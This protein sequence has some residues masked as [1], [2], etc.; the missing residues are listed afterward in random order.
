MLDNVEATTFVRAM[1]NG[2]TKPAL[3]FAE[4]LDGSEIEVVAKFSAGCGVGGL[5]REAISSC[6]ATDLGLPM[7][8]A[9]LIDLTPSFIASVPD[10]PMQQHMAAGDFMA[11]ATVKLPNG[12]ASWIDTGADLAPAL[13]RQAQEILCF[14]C[15]VTNA[16]RMHKN[17]NLLTDGTSFAIFDHELALAHTMN[18]F[19][20][21]PWI[22]K[23]LDQARPPVEHV[24][25]QLLRGRASYAL[26]SLMTRLAALTDGRIDSYGS[27]L[28][29]SWLAAEP[30]TVT[31]TVG[32]VKDLRDQAQAAL[33]EFTRAMT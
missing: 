5:V 3:L 22:V 7:P 4:R 21:P 31:S 1:G 6:L 20:K 2:R 8:E 18:L 16:D 28:P 15:W 13:D 23:A 25:F 33:T 17:R 26:N 29:Q 27:A 24:F 30:A 10:I 14:D 11:F 12:F 9:L 19:W 32:F